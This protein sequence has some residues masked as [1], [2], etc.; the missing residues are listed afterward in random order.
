MNMSEDTFAVWSQGPKPTEAEKVANAESIIRKAIEADEQ[1]QKLDVSVFCQG[2]YRARTNVKEDSDID[3]CVRYN[4][5]FNP[6]YP[7]G[8]SAGDF[9]HV[10][11][12]LSYH[13]FKD[14][15]G[16][17]LIQRFGSAGVSRGNKAFDVHANT[18]RIDADV[19]AAFEHRRYEDH[20]TSYLSGIAF[21]PDNGG[22]VR[23]WPQQNYDNGVNKND[24]CARRYKRAVRILKRLC[25][26]M[27]DEG[28]QEAKNIPSFLLEC[29]VWN[30]PD[31]DFQHDTYSADVRAVL[32]HIFNETIKESTCSEWGEVN[33]LKYLF[34]SSQPWTREQAHNFVGAAWGYIGFQ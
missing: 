33:E 11:A 22:L 14:F 9:G 7:P 13:V 10:D 3:I 12:W 21:W 16:R 24:R 18:Y 23:N 27:Q 30:V 28:I 34:R 17:A 1:L 20:S 32:A 19:V 6:E 8:K 31:E 5:A 2:S 26:K 25:Y 15:V 29:L 4:D